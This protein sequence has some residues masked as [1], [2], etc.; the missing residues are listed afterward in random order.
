MRVKAY[1]RLEPTGSVGS[2]AVNFGQTSIVTS[3]AL[4]FIAMSLVQD[5]LLN[6]TIGRAIDVS[7]SYMVLISVFVLAFLRCR[8][9]FSPKNLGLTAVVLWPLALLL[10]DYLYLSRYGPVSDSGGQGLRN[11]AYLVVVAVWFHSGTCLSKGARRPVLPSIHVVRGGP[12]IRLD[13]PRD[14]KRASTL[15]APAPYTAT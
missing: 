1:N 7:S 10:I 13:R 6:K 9:F 8:T 12:M 15:S 3:V 2:N 4:A 11:A 14:G 5:A